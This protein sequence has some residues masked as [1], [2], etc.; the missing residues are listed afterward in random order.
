[1]YK[2]VK[3]DELRDLTLRIL[4]AAGETKEDALL[5]FENLLEDEYMGRSSHGFNRV[6]A[7]A[8]YSNCLLYTSFDKMGQRC[9]YRKQ[10]KCRHS[11]GS[12]VRAR[13]RSP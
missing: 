10:K 8:R 2:T 13:K 1:M 12:V 3:V 5:V 4:T 9:L 6:P 11:H 7:I